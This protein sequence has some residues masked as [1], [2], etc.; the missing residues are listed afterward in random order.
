[1]EVAAPVIDVVDTV[2]AGDS[3]MAGILDH[4]IEVDLVGAARGNALRD[5]TTDEVTRMLRRAVRIAAITCQRPG[6]DPP[7]AGELMDDV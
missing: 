2:G 3:F 7:S 4:L 5:I 1:V 6:A